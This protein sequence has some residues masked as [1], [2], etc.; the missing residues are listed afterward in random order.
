MNTIYKS[1]LAGKLVI[2]AGL[3]RCV[4]LAIL[5]GSTLLALQTQ[6]VNFTPLPPYLTEIKGAPMIMLNMSRDHQLFYKAYNEYSD[7]DEDGLVETQY[8]HSYKYY[9]YFDNQRCYT[10]NTTDNQ[11][12][13]VGKVDAAGYCTNATAADNWNGN[14]MN[15]AT[16]TRMDVVRR[17]L[18]GGFRAV[19]TASAA[20]PSV[21][22]SVLERA[23]LTSD[24]HAFAKYYYGTDI[25]KLTPFNPGSTTFTI[26]TAAGTTSV[27][28]QQI[29]LCNASFGNDQA[30]ANNSA[31]R[32]SIFVANGNHALWN[33]NERWQCYWSEV[34]GANNGNVPAD[35]GLFASTSNPSRVAQGLGT[36]YAAGSYTARVEVCKTGLTGGF[37]ADEDS[38]CKLY[39][40]GNYKPIGL[41]Q[42]YGERDE[43]AFGLMTGSFDKNISGGVLRKNVASFKD[44][45]DVD[46]GQ[47]KN[48]D[49]IVRTLNRLKITGYNYDDGNYENLV[50][51]CNYQQ[52]GLTDGQCRSWGNPLGEMYLES[53]RYFA[54]KTPTAAFTT[55]PADRDAAIGLSITA[56][57]DPSGTSTR[58]NFG[59]ETCRRTNIINFN[60][61]VTT[62]DSNQWS[63]AA[64]VTGLTTAIVDNYTNQ[65][66]AA[67]GL[68]APG[69]L[70]SVGRNG[71]DN[72]GF[73]SDKSITATGASSFAEVTGICPEA[74][75]QFGGY[76]MAGL[77]LWSR[78]NRIRTDIA[79]PVSNRRAFKIETFGVALATGTPRIKIP[80]P[81]VANRFVFISPSYR[82]SVGVG[83]GGTLVDFK[84]VYQTATRGKY[85][86]N[87]EDSE[88]GG[89]FDQDVLGILEYSVNTS[90]KVISVTTKVVAQATANPQ[91]FGYS[92]SGTNAQDGVHFHSG[93]IG[94]N[95]NDPRNITVT[96]ATK[97]NA[98]GGCNNCQAGE[99]ATTAVYAMLGVSGDDLKDP[100]WYSAKYGGLDLGTSTYV[101]GS[102]PT[103]SSW[104]AK[105]TDGS[106][107]ADGVPDNYYFAVDP[108]QLEKSLSQVFETI[109]KTGGAAPAATSAKTNVGGFVYQSAFDIKAKTDLA[110]AQAGGKFERFSFLADGTAS[111]LAD[112][113]AGL[114]LTTQDW[115]TGR[116]ILSL[117]TAGPIT[118]RWA[119]LTAQQKRALRKDQ[120]AIDTYD[121]ATAG[122]R[123]FDWI[124]G[125]SSRETSTGGLRVRSTTKLGA[126]VNSTPW[127]VGPPSA[128]Y[129]E[130]DYGG[131]YTSFRNTNTS[132]NAVFVGANDGMLHAFD[133]ATGSELFAYVPRAMYKTTTVA[134]F[135]QLSAMT[136]KDFALNNGTSRMTVDGSLM[137]ADMKVGTT[138]AWAT[139]L[140]G[141]FGR[142]GKGVYA[143]DVTK[144]QN[145]IEDTASATKLVKWEFS[146]ETGDPDMGFITGRP[147]SRSN[148]QPF[149]TG[150]MANGKWAAIYGNGYNSTN[151]NAV[152]YILYA[153]GP[154]A[155]TTTWTTGTHYIKIPTGVAGNGDNG[156]GTP[157]A[158][159]SNNDGNIDIIYAGDLKGN[160]WKFDVSNANPA[161]WKVA[162]T[163]SVPLYQARTTLTANTATVVVQPITTVVQPFPH[164]NG[165]YQLVFGTGKSLESSDYPLNAPFTNTIYA[166]YDRPGNTTTLTVGLTELVMKSTTVAGNVRYI[167]NTTVD[168]STKKGWYLNLPL[169]SEA[170]VFNPLAQGS[171]RI[172]LKS[173]APD[174][175]S[176]GCRVDSISFDMELNTITGNAIVN[177][178]EGATAI[179]GF[180]AAGSSAINS[181]EV[182]RGGIYRK[183]DQLA[184][185]AVCT[186]GGPNVV[187]NPKNPAECVVCP[188]PANCCPP[189]KPCETCVY[190][191]LSA[192]GT[193]GVATTLRYGSCSDGRLTW[194][195]ILRNR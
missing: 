185:S 21:S 29:T 69:K 182:G 54:G 138:P 100:L 52:I 167:E 105:G 140:F 56:W 107:G 143:L 33:A 180:I 153:D 45:V 137:A 37:T 53:V 101:L 149:Q 77:A 78:L 195:E 73:C 127:Y 35:T 66:G 89:D 119:N 27:T 175:V 173:I 122:E 97:I 189:W 30:P 144:P 109:L 118:F 166:I 98:S 146:E 59:D 148:G 38:R 80:V 20:T 131:G 39:P 55:T 32:P 112:W 108:T 63:S 10:Y 88:Q 1:L 102:T 22:V 150:R 169:A 179:P 133:A 125:D 28:A 5:I 115:S 9:G 71:V 139:Y 41:L 170:L 91:G 76:K 82:L 192:L 11:Y 164:P 65:I 92:I 155:S 49:G 187:Y 172:S 161:N 34:R 163:G 83:G 7:L 174:G 13:P 36:G 184:S 75:T 162:T 111:S 40:R 156:L 19:D 106:T 31:S 110:D 181:F 96:P 194:R 61:S 136:A 104:D 74:P 81:G 157:I 103:L 132:T 120:A 15:W 171:N 152:L 147:S 17:I 6:A 190:R 58:A 183:S 16:M 64:D 18:Y 67:E 134:P 168:Y 12:E 51:G 159:D 46:D 48:V 177:S 124:R 62:F 87:W 128:G 2:N 84:V 193:G 94:F 24:A 79:A 4:K 60:A 160:V 70:W 42:R 43:A 44:E 130:S 176:D 117:S 57:S 178:V 121:N 126:I 141:T 114:K 145:I 72:N 50:G 85:V 188:D 142:G 95:Y 86:I 186:A 191:T 116:K 129:T 23:H 123:K 14:F 151:E 99:A 25:S 8:K 68:Y 3:M 135:S 165:G 93:I 154:I 113:D 90:T 158:I 47:F 26:S